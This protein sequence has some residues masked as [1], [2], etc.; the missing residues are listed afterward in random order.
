MISQL[1]ALHEAAQAE[2]VEL[3]ARLDDGAEHS[4]TLLARLGSLRRR[5][6]EILAGQGL[7][8]PTHVVDRER[9]GLVALDAVNAALKA[10]REGQTPQ[11]ARAVFFREFSA[12]LRPTSQ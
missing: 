5:Y 2:L 12:V 7:T 8:R 6:D 3:A 10:I 9:L 4:P 11:A 1:E